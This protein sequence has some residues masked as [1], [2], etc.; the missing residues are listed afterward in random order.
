M[1]SE[2]LDALRARLAD[3]DRVV[4]RA[5]RSG[6]QRELTVVGYGEISAVLRLEGDGAAFAAKLLPRFDTEQRLLSYER[7]VREY[8]A[9]LRELGV[10]VIDSMILAARQRDKLALDPRPHRGAAHEPGSAYCVQPLVPEPLLCV[11]QLRRMDLAEGRELAAE[12]FE[13]IARVVP[14]RGASPPRLGFDA[15]I[16]NWY[17][18]AG[19]LVYLDVTTPLM[20]SPA[21]VEALDTELFLA[22][23][24]Y[25]ARGLVR[26]FLLAEV[27]DNYYDLQRVT[28]DVLGN[29]IKEGLER[30]LPTWLAVASE[31][32]SSGLE[33]D[34]VRRH[35]ARDARTWA[36]LQRLRRLDRRWQRAVR[37]EPYGFL[38]P[39][40]VH[41]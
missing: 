20:R 8:V 17:R 4:Q 33:L 37:D 14:A 5:L 41:R 12:L 26:R 28:L 38:L 34:Q 19:R 36:L 27:L 25:A 3:L 9:R 40:I 35:Y 16:S 15:Q 32:T 11:Q 23:L 18:E 24:P 1:A 31:H 2:E 10:E 29:L 22:S 21:G 6:D 39:P 13:L 7:S 30:H